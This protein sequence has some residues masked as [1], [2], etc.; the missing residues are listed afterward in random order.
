MPGQPMYYVTP[1]NAAQPRARARLHR[2]G[3]HPEV[4]AEGIVK[5]FNWYPGI[6]A[7]NIQNAIDQ[8]TWDKLFADVTPEDLATK[9]KSFPIGPY[10]DDILEA[11][12]KN[13]EN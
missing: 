12:E 6:D 4:Q 7:Q 11:Y 9:G 13:V 3:D 1:A 5:T 10:F 2:A 8:A